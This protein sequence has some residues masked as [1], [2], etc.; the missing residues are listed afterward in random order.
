MAR[1]YSIGPIVGVCYKLKYNVIDALLSSRNFDPGNG[2]DVFI[3]LNTLLHQLAGNNKYIESLQFASNSDDKMFTETDMIENILSVFKHWKNYMRKFN[4]SRI[5]VIVNDLDIT[6]LPEKEVLKQYMSPFSNKFK[7]DK[8]AQ[9]A[10]YWTSSLKKIEEVLKYIP[11]LYL[12][13]SIRFDSYVIP[14]LIDDYAHNQRFRIILTGNA[15]MTNYQLYDRTIVLY[16]RFK[17]QTTD[18]MII[19]QN[20]SNINNDIMCTFIKNKVFYTLLNAIIGDFDRGIIGMTQIGLSTFANDLLRAV[21]VGDI[22]Q[23]PK[24]IESVL[25]VVKTMHHKYLRQVY[26]LI[27]IELHS[28]LIPQSMVE[29]LR[30]LMIDIM[31]VD[32]IKNVSVGELHLMELL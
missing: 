29:R 15:M 32:A 26:P 27:D 4:N 13:R 24:N 23:S 28:Q 9:F 8:I 22:P 16:K 21:E 6:A 12:I 7:S 31:D 30:A 14:N 3:D 18:P 25:P 5:F 1:D 19:V 2:V 20:I 17:N 10:Y 11:G